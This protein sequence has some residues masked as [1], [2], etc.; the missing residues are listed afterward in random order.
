M[1]K[2]EKLFKVNEELAA[3]AALDKHTKEGLFESLKREKKCNNR[4]K[5]LN[6]LGE[7]NNGPILFSATVV[8]TAQAIAVEKEEKE[9]QERARIDANKEAAAIK[10]AK[11]D[12]EKA[13]EALQAAI[14]KEN[15]AEVEAE[16]KAKKQAQKQ[17]EIVTNKASKDVLAKAKGPEKAKKAPVRERKVVQFVGVDLEEVVPATSQKQTSSGRAV[18]APVIF[19]KGT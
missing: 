17:K 12:A 8:R 4:G 13:E 16:E 6:V 11:K 2:L 19:E 3:Q 7:E 9:K 10:K 15:K 1:A 14:R 5:R 18:K